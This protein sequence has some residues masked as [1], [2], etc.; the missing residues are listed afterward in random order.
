MSES[1]SVN[2]AAAEISQPDQLLALRNEMGTRFAAIQLQQ[3]QE[4]AAQTTKTQQTVM[5]L[6][7]L[8]ESSTRPPAPTQL[9]ADHA[10][11]QA[12]AAAQAPAAAAPVPEGGKGAPMAD[13][14]A[15]AFEGAPT[16]P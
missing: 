3:Q 2:A 10:A 11:T 4:S 12:T 5:E 13:P 16:K 14:P 6:V 7:Q 9:A 15:G 8:I 1:V